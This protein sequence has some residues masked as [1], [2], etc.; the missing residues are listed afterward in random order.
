MAKS[1]T[2]EQKLCNSEIA[3]FQER[4]KTLSFSIDGLGYL[5]KQLKFFV[6]TSYVLVIN[7]VVKEQHET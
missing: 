6:L 1:V 7:L 5:S 2:L 4:Q 3:T